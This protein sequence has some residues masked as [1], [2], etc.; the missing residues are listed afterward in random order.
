[1][2]IASSD[3]GARVSYASSYHD[4]YPPSNVIDK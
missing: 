4:E 2:D 3:S 1:M